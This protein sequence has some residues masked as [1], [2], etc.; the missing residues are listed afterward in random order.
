MA[1]DLSR[2]RV[3]LP[4]NGLAFARVLATHTALRNLTE[5]VVFDPATQQVIAH[6]GYTTSFTLDPPPEDAIST[7][8]LGEVAVLPADD[9][10]RAVVALDFGEG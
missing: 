10:V 4:D 6:A 9:R 3:L 2:A 5:A 7:A 8:R 1:A